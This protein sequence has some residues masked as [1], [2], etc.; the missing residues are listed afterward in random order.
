M[1]DTDTV[2]YALRGAGL[3]AGRILEHRPS[4]LCISSITLAELRF[5]AALR[6]SPRLERLIDTFAATIEVS[7]FDSKAA[8]EFGTL[9]AAL[10]RR[11]ASIGHMDALIASHAM[12]LDLI[13][14]TNNT[15]H[16][17]RIAGLRTDNWI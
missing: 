2:S 4:Q 3:V 6:G 10:N 5:G 15:R 8:D 7:P 14:V 9:A 1:L 17:G 13:L 12:A 11:G 16:F